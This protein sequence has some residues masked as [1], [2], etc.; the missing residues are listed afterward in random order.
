MANEIDWLSIENKFL[1]TYSYLK[2]RPAKEVR[3]MVGLQ[4]LKATYRENDESVVV[5]WVENPYWQ[6]FCGEV[7]FQSN[8]PINPT[9]MTKFRNRLD[10]NK[11]SDLLG[12][13]IKT[14]LKF[15]II[16]H[17]SLE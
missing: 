9:M 3:L 1:P 2:G 15:K 14:G 10:K 4:Y 12:E 17:K 7:Y 5:K 11:I 13:L 6:Y 8:C 16:T